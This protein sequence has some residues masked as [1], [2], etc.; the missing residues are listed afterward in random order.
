MDYPNGQD[1]DE[2]FLQALQSS[3]TTHLAASLLSL[4]SSPL[5]LDLSP[6]LRHGPINLHVIGERKHLLRQI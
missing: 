1:L 6:N 5:P 3:L 4:F 2:Y